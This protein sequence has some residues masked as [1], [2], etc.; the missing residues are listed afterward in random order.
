MQHIEYIHINGRYMNKCICVSM[1]VFQPK[2]QHLI[3]LETLEPLPRKLG[4]DKHVYYIDFYL[5][6]CK[7]YGQCK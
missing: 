5:I 6:L 3:Y 1:C 2:D 7:S 4:K